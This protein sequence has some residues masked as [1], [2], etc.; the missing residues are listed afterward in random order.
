MLRDRVISEEELHAYVDGAAE[1]ARRLDIALFLARHPHD[2]ARIESFRAQNAAIHALFDPDL[3][4][5]VP[6]RLRRSVRR[7]GTRSALRRYFA[8]AFA[9]AAWI[10]GRRRADPPIPPPLKRRPSIKT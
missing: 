2:A 9:V 4:Q 8:W 6:P 5:P 3:A 1:P 7:Q 10:A